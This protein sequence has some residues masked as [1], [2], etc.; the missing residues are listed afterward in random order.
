MFLHLLILS[1]FG[2]GFGAILPAT[3]KS[4]FKP[5]KSLNLFVFKR[6]YIARYFIRF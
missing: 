2:I 5:K 4:E 3:V 1:F 6:I